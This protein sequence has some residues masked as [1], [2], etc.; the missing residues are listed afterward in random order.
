ME[1]VLVSMSALLLF[2]F[3]CVWLLRTRGVPCLFPSLSCTHSHALT[4]MHLTEHKCMG[5]C[6][7]SEKHRDARYLRQASTWIWL[8]CKSLQVC[9]CV[10]VCVGVASVSVPESVSVRVPVAVYG[11]KRTHTY[12]YSHACIFFLVLPYIC[13]F[14][15]FFYG[16]VR[17]GN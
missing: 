1:N 13:A 7:P 9:V 15:F 3:V 10:C 2:L 14:I 4:H 11:C 17:C 8:D 5:W 12:V 6:V 16:M